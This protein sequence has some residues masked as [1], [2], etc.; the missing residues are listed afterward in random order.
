[1]F[2]FSQQYPVFGRV[3]NEQWEWLVR[4]IGPPNSKW[5]VSRGAVWFKDS[6]HKMLYILRWS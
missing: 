6:S 5:T 4:V 3:S 2:K 1:M